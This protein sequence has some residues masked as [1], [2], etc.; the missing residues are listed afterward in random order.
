MRT[1]DVISAEKLRGGFYSPPTLV[2]VCLDRIAALSSG[3]PGPLRIFEPSAGDGAFIRGLRDHSIADRVKDLTAVELNPG[4]AA[5]CR[6]VL[7]ATAFG[8]TVLTGS[9][10]NGAR[11]VPGEY[12]TEVGNPPFVR[13]PS[14]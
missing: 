9:V 5:K 14:S 7:A 13:L 1:I 11:P 2:H 8:G 10:L 4:E 12:N 6:Q 3:A